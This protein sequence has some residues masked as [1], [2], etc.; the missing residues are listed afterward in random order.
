MMA[1]ADFRVRHAFRR[2]H[3]KGLHEGCDH[4]SIAMTLLACMKKD[5]LHCVCFVPVG[6]EMRRSSA[7]TNRPD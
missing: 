1:S 3:H 4:H 7:M 5:E 6:S 2:I